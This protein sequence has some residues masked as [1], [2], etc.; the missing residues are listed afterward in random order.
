MPRWIETDT[1]SNQNISSALAIGAYTADAD[2]L[3]LV[4]FFADQV[5]GNGDYIFYITQRLGGAGSSYRHIPITTAAAASGVTAIAGQSGMIAVRSGDV[6]TVYLDGLAGDTTTPDTSV[7]WFE[8]DSMALAPTQGMITW[9]QQTISANI[10]GDAALVVTNSNITGLGARIQGNLGDVS[11][12]ITGNLSGSVGSVTAGV[13]ISGTL[14]TLDAIWAKIQKWLRLALRKD[15][16][17]ATDHATE[18][19]EINANGGSGAGSYANITDSQEAISDRIGTATVTVVSPVSANGT[20]ITVIR[21]D[22][23]LLTDGRQLAWTSASWPT[24]TS[25][26]VKLR[27]KFAK[28]ATVTEYSAT[29]TGAQA[30]YVALTTTQTAA[31]VPGV[32]NFDLQ[33]TLSNLSV[34]TLVQGVLNVRE[35]V[36]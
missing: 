20:A 9:D 24:L 7:R 8:L 12:D 6:L 21:G 14:T 22:D 25:G 1:L 13:T 32:Y 30:C 2:R 15:S 29:L 33:A 11:G 3:I 10:N 34:V 35:D 26:T 17:V 23:Y 36:R 18:L 5:A 16:A 31:M 28:N 19:T 4:Q 27:V